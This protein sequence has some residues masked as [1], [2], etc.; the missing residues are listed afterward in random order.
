MPTARGA[1]APGRARLPQG[2]CAAAGSRP[3][4]SAIAGLEQERRLA[5]EVEE[6]ALAAQERQRAA[7]REGQ[8]RQARDALGR[9]PAAAKQ[10]AGAASEALRAAEALLAAGGC[11]GGCLWAEAHRAGVAADATSRQG[12]RLCLRLADVG[13]RCSR[14]TS[15]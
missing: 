8:R 15:R 2:S 10:A 13:R 4:R 6:L 12:R 7:A 11:D 9:A 14:A 5:A 3:P 1:A